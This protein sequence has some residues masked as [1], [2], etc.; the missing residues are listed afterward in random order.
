M[1]T[2]TNRQWFL[3]KLTKD[4]F[5]F[6]GSFWGILFILELIKNG[7][8]SNYFSLP[9]LALWVF[10]F[11]IIALVFDTNTGMSQFDQNQGIKKRERVFLV[12]FSVLIAFILII[13]TNF[14]LPL[15]L[16]LIFVTVLALWSVVYTKS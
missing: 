10:L 9:H 16:L 14:S 15:T 13:A 1:T 3:K 11:G 7:L 8:V 5:F 4:L 12:L 2:P 6:S